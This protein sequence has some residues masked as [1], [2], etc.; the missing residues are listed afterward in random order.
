VNVDDDALVVSS[1][2]LATLNSAF[3]LVMDVSLEHDY[4]TLPH[5][6]PQLLIRL[7]V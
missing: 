3:E 6:H 1:C 4:E 5:P 7:L 2:L